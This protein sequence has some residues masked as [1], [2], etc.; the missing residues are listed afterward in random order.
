MP[1]PG[2]KDLGEDKPQPKPLLRTALG[3]VLRRTR[4]EQGRI[5]ADV[6]R[7]AKISM[8]Y[9]SE[10]ERGRKEVSSEVLAA[11]CDSLK[12]ELPDLLS[13]V[14]RDLD[15]DR[16]VSSVVRLDAFRSRRASSRVRPTPEA[17]FLLAA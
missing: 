7:S 12:I 6:A 14:R 5:L 17:R 10:V 3:D 9:L 2:V 4:L 16:Q 8:P 15:A 1:D 13:E 11:I